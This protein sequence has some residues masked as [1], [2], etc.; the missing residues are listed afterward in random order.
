MRNYKANDETLLAQAK[1]YDRTTAQILVRYSLQK[2]WVSLPKSE[3]PSRIAANADV[4]GFEI[5]KE[6]MA[7]L[8][9][10]DQGDAGAIVQAVRN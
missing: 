7:T 8:D 6:D 5:S 10:L 4:Y 2:G 3:N 1:K 9:G